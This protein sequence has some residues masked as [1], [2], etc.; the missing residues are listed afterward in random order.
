MRSLTLHSAGLTVGV[1]GVWPETET[2]FSNGLQLLLS[3]V[4]VLTGGRDPLV[5]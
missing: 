2:P 5:T 1:L 4:L 3:H